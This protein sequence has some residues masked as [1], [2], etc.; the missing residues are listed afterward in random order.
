MTHWIASA[1]G[2][3]KSIAKRNWTPIINSTPGDLHLLVGGKPLIHIFA[4]EQPEDGFIP[5]E[6]SLKT[7]FSKILTE[8]ISYLLFVAR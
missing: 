6:A 1:A 8:L 4:D 3:E 7:F 5:A 2:W